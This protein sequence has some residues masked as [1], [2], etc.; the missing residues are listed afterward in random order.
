MLR[1]LSLG[2]PDAVTS[3]SASTGV[4]QIALL[5][6]TAS[7][8]ALGGCSADFLRFDAPV[9]NL[10]DDDGRDVRPVAN[11]AGDYAP[12]GST[13]AEARRDDYDR[14]PTAMTMRPE[15]RVLGQVARA[16]P[17]QRIAPPQ[18]T[19]R[20]QPQRQQFAD[21]SPLATGALGGSGSGRITV[22]RGDTLY[23]LS[24]RHGVSVAALRD[25]NNLTGNII[26]PGQTLV[27]PSRGGYRAP[28]TAARAPAP[29]LTAPLTRTPVAGGGGRVVTV[30]PG[31]SL[32]AISRRTGV[33]VS[34]IK[35]LNGITDAR[36]LRPGMQLSLGDTVSR[37]ARRNTMPKS[38]VAEAQRPVSRTDFGQA[39]KIKAKPIRTVSIGRDMA[40]A[41][42]TAPTSA[43]QPRILNGGDGVARAPAVPAKRTRTAA[44]DEAPIKF[45]WP[46][47]GRIIA[48]FNNSGTGVK[49]D[50]INISLPIGT[51]IHAVD[52]GTV[53]YSGS[54]LK[55]YGNLVLLRHENGWVSAYAHASELL[56]KRGDKVT[57]GQVVAK[58]GRSGG[59]TQPQLHFELR[60]EAQPVDPLPHMAQM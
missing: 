48:T 32:Y 42:S 35:Q 4:R 38:V 40:P 55:G 19:V 14:S 9:F 46:A 10:G 29:R 45:R 33:S 1:S 30:V 34:R 26:R 47:K 7:A 59:V 24:R 21:A 31:D 25:A 50:G 41:P 12:T 23:Q 17:A 52:D 39:S 8:V 15:Q 20:A 51:P 6:L 54:E 37:T 18:R 58:A 43:A 3:Y 27:L 53:A 22:E 60:K 2:R 11:R 44:L 36:R 56:V 16:E 5:M 49:N 57:K 28:R 13:L